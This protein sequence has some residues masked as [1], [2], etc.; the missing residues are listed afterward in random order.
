MSVRATE[1]DR[2]EVAEQ[3][4]ERRHPGRASASELRSGDVVVRLDP[5]SGRPDVVPAFEADADPGPQRLAAV[6][7]IVPM[8]TALM[9]AAWL[10]LR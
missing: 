5:A 4:V 8:L 7:V 9:I 10:W 2:S 6:A 3:A 1:P